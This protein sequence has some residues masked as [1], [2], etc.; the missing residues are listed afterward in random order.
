MAKAQGMSPEAHRQVQS[1][2]KAIEGK[3]VPPATIAAAVDAIKNAGPVNIKP[4]VKTAIDTLH[5][6]GTWDEQNHPRAPA[7]SSQGGEFI[8]KK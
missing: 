8:S 5:G 1:Y 2:L 7:G 3:G 4:A 6:A